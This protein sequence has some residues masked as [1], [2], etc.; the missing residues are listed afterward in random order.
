MR[1]VLFRIFGL[2]IPSYGLMLVIS[3]LA[4]IFLVR[5]SAKK[6]N[7]PAAVVE[8]LA[9]WVMVGVIIGGRLLYVFFHL[10]EYYDFFT[11]FEVWRGGMMFFGGFLGAIVA[12]LIYIR[13]TKL[14]VMLLADLVAPS[15]ALGEFFTRIGCFLNGCCFGLQCSLPW[16]IKFPSDSIAGQSPVGEFHLHPTQLY[17]SLFGLLLFIFLF[18]RSRRKHLRGELFGLYLAI[19]GLYRLGIDFIRY[20]ENSANLWVNQLISIG[21]IIFGIALYVISLKKKI[22]D[23][24]VAVPANKKA[25]P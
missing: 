17:S 15:I 14:P 16:G 24:A 9:F 18:L 8:N 5:K 2:G 6:Y 23:K 4:A 3:F 12:G 7:I 22:V 21:V 20:Y 11:I 1:P 10:N 13:T 19:S 25:K